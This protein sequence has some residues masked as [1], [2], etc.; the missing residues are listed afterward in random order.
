[1]ITIYGISDDLVEV[2]GCEGAD[3][4]NADSLD[5][6]HADLV[7]P[8]GTEQ[9]RVHCWFDS[10]GCWQ[11]GVGQTVED[12]QMPP[13]PVSITQRPHRLQE[14]TGQPGYSLQLNIDAPAGTR[15]TNIQERNTE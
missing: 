12:C 3:E 5:R 9:L 6:W 8:G 14:A 13:W 2:E 7:A 4:F 15:I 10:G 1:M 11:V